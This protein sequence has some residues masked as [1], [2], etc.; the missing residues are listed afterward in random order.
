MEI[1]SRGEGRPQW[2][3]RSIWV[4]CV[5][6]GLPGYFGALSSM[7][8]LSV[9]LKFSRLF[10][11]SISPQHGLLMCELLVTTHISIRVSRNDLLFGLGGLLNWRPPMFEQ[12]WPPHPLIHFPSTLGLPPFKGRPNPQDI[13]HVERGF[14]HVQE[15]FWTLLLKRFFFTFPVYQ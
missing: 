13:E 10:F 3:Y 15:D 9:S 5:L 1:F 8:S 7:K 6:T 2:F 11:P 12:F 14:Q 4:R